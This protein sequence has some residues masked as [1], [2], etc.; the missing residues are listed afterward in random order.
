VNL[1]S[2]AAQGQRNRADLAN[3]IATIGSLYTGAR[4]KPA[5]DPTPAPYSGY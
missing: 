5:G 1:G 3:T 2:T 4:Q